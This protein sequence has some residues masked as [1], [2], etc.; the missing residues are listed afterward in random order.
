M[1]P[2][3][4]QP[5]IDSPPVA[6]GSGLTYALP[7]RYEDLGKLGEGGMGLVIKARDKETGETVALKLLRPEIAADSEAMERF[8]NELR[9]ARRITHRNVCR[10]YEF[11][12][13]GQTAYISMECV[14]GESLRHLLRRTKVPDFRQGIA[15]A[16]QICEALSEAHLQGVVHRDLKPENV[17]LDL[18]GQVKLMDFG[19]ARKFTGGTT[20]TVIVGTPSYMSPEQAEGKHV[21]HRADVYSLGLV[22]Y[23]I[24]TGQQAVPSGALMQV[25]LKQINETPPPPRQVR[26]DLPEYLDRAILKCVEKDASKRFQS[27]ADLKAALLAKGREPVTAPSP[28]PVKSRWRILGRSLAVCAAIAAVAVLGIVAYRRFHSPPAPKQRSLVVLPFTAATGTTEEDRILCDALTEAVTNMLAHVPSLTVPPARLV[29][30]RAGGSI[31][32]ARV[33]LGADVVLEVSWQRTGGTVQLDV[34]LSNA[35]TLQV[36]QR[37]A[38]LENTSDAFVL[39]YRIAT[40]VWQMLGI[41]QPPEEAARANSGTSDAAA[42][43]DYLHGRG[44]LQGVPKP[45]MVEAAISFFKRAVDRDPNFVLADASLGQA[46]VLKFQS[47]SESKWLDEALGVCQRAAVL[48]TELPAAYVCLGLVYTEKGQYERAV[49][50]LQQAV[51]LDIVNDDAYLALGHAFEKLGKFDE[52]EATYG[53]AVRLRPNYWR[54]HSWLGS[55]YAQRGRFP[56]STAEFQKVVALAPDSFE[57]YSNLGGVLMYQNRVPEAIAAL[58]KSI[59]I[60]PT[61][62][63]YSNLGTVYLDSRQFAEAARNYEKALQLSD[64]DYRIW[65]NLGEA[66]LWIPEQKAL[67]KGAYRNAA[68]R[69]EKQRR[70]N[71][72]DG[73]VVVDLARYSAMLDQRKMA[74]DLLKEGLIL[75]NN[76]SEVDV[77]AAKIYQHFGEIDKTLDYLEKAVRAGADLED[78]ATIPNFDSLRELPRYKDLVRQRKDVTLAK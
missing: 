39:Q 2:L 7:E 35:K 9:L 5:T 64:S 3:E 62:D 6:P 33:D 63:G 43:N 22:L 58:E 31:E 50:E 30:E 18:N 11:H 16:I 10:I 59:A 27:I 48:R 57:S 23:E 12:R 36:L 76:D 67:A 1:S 20:T 70:T 72:R 38:L 73:K 40:K 26:P 25:L 34:T 52:A 14:E 46:Y 55:F 65:G 13:S 78:L 44:L 8:K 32:K 42:Y 41:E 68:L 19:V 56:E 29:R 51:R 61:A 37:A 21:D 53:Q 49:T 28:E 17:M 54:A 77:N 74:F 15:I 69:A 75:A 60:R 4:D 71:P 66:Y 47:G 45:E 24:F